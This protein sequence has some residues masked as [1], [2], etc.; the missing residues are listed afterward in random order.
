L[1]VAV[2]SVFVLISLIV[3]RFFQLSDPSLPWI[4]VMG[5]GVI[6]FAIGSKWLLNDVSF[7]AD[8]RDMWPVFSAAMAIAWLIHVVQ[9][10]SYAA[11]SLLGRL[12]GDMTVFATVGLLHFSS[13]PVAA[14]GDVLVFGPPSLVGAVEVTPLCGGFLSVLMFIVAFNFVTLEVG[15]SLGFTRLTFLLATGIVMTIV[16][17]VLRVYVVTVVGFYYGLNALNLAHTYLGYAL[18]LSIASAF[19]YVALRW[20]KVRAAHSSRS[21]TGNKTIMDN[22]SHL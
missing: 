5:G 19:W 1:R 8:Y 10:E 3:L 2:G 14:T 11:G 12:F 15:R 13:L 21:N 18:F 6:L 20:N 9:L 22:S 16:A 17:A 7:F 4:T